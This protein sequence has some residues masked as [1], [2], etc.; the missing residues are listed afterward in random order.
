FIYIPYQ[1]HLPRPEIRQYL[2]SIKINPNRVL[3]I[4]FPA[5]NVLGLLIYV[6]YVPD[7]SKILNAVNT[8]ILHD[9]NPT[10][11]SH[12]KD[13]A[14]TSLPEQEKSEI[15]IRCHR[16]RCL[17]TLAWLKNHAKHTVA[18]LFCH[19]G[20]LTP[21]DVSNIIKPSL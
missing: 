6:Q 1:K 20:W 5:R 9:F 8:P 7:V 19:N 3:D 4:S 18:H 16:N 10:D 21:T 15:A 13:P 12:I 14:Y 17:H 2:R 11:A